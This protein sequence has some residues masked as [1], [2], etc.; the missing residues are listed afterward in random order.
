MSENEDQMLE[1]EVSDQDEEEEPAEGNSTGPPAENGVPGDEDE[2]DALEGISNAEPDS[3]IAPANVDAV[4]GDV[5]GAPPDPPP[6]ARLSGK[7]KLM[8]EA[9]SLEHKLSHLPKNP[10]CHSCTMG[11]MTSMHTDVHSRERWKSGDKSLLVIMS[12]QR[13][14]LHWDWM[15]RQNRL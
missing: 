6:Q 3:D 1:N 2:G 12:I 8:L 14:P 5:V 10:F 13:L 15:A 4:N 9:Q 11:K 7:D